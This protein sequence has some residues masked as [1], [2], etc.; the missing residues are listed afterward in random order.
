MLLT[1]AIGLASIASAVAF[2]ILQTADDF[3]LESRPQSYPVQFGGPPPPPGGGWRPPPPPPG[4]Y[5]PPP[6]PPGGYRPGPLPP[7][8]YNWC[9]RKYRSYRPYDNT[10]QPYQGPRRS[11]RSPFWN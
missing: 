9:A 1:G 4:G 10:F 8:H 2:P 3:R 5:R 6:P 11:C 7:Q